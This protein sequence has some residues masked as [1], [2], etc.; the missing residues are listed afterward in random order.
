MRTKTYAQSLEADDAPERIDS[1]TH[2]ITLQGECLTY[3]QRQGVPPTPRPGK[4]RSCLGMSD[5][6]RF[7]LLKIANRLDWEKCGTCWFLTTTYPDHYYGMSCQEMSLHRSLWQRAQEKRVGRNVCVIWRT[8]HQVRKSG[9]W[10][11]HLMPHIHMI[12][13]GVAEYRKVD[14]WREWMAAIGEWRYA[15]VDVE[16]MESKAHVIQYVCEYVGKVSPVLGIASNLS[17]IPPGRAWGIL[18]RNLLPLHETQEIRCTYSAEL[19]EYVEKALTPRPAI[20]EW[21]NR[22][23][24]LLGAKA[25]AMWEEICERGLAGGETT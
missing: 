6:S 15:D 25:K 17:R 19:Q 2:R 3:Q 20:N 18:R 1:W 11:G 16:R 14:L 24:T 12:A 5:A 9:K 13:I 23:F 22:G 10:K 4:R 7:R 8:E 21:G